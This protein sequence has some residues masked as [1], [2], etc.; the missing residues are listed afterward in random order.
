MFFSQ[1]EVCSNA[2][3]VLVHQSIYDEF[4]RKVV[5]F[6]KN[7]VPDDPLLDKTKVGA[8]ISSE[9]MLRVKAFIDGA[10]QEVGGFAFASCLFISI[11]GMNALTFSHA[12]IQI[13]HWF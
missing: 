7:L 8:T 2:S 11:N 12:E 5:D 6:T 9:H 3:K 1:G 4:R 13:N 10:C